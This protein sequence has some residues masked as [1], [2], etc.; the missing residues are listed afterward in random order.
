MILNVSG[1][2]D[3]VAFYSDWF[4]NRYNEGFVDVRNPFN[5]KMI[6]RIYFEDVDAILFCTKNPTPMLDKIQ[7]I[8]K[9]ILFH[10]TLTPYKRD[11]ELNVPDKKDVINSIK[12]LSKIIGID[13]L[14][15]RYDPIFISD[16]YTVDYHIKA[17]DKLCTILNGYV[18]YFIVSFI[19]DYKNVRK[20][21]KVLNYKG[22]TED[23][24]K[25][26]GTNFSKSA[27]NNGMSVQTCFEDRNLVEYGFKK[28]ENK[29]IFKNKIYNKQFEIVVI[30][31]DKQKT[32]KL[33]DLANDEEYIMVDIQDC[34]GKFVGEIRQEYE[35]TIQDI[36]NKCTIDEI[37]KNQQSKEVIKYIKEKYDDDLEFLWKKYDNNAIW[38]NKQNNKWYGVLLV[39]SSKKLGLDYD[40]EIEILDLR[41][42]KDEIDKI[43]DN[44]KIYPG[45]H[46]NKKSWITINLDNT[47]NINKIYK[48]IDNSYNLIV[49]N[50]CGLTGDKLSQKVYDYLITIPKGKVV[51]YKQIGEFLGNKGLARAIGNILHKNPDGDKYP[52]YKVLNSKGE[53]AEAF[54]FG[55]KDIQRKRLEKDGIKVVNN[56]VDLKIYQW[57]QN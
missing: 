10:V 28:Q 30:I 39:I 42:Q 3:I 29:Y 2:T 23:D 34:A 18:K 12:K 47:V 40:K 4:M 54:V 20:N 43:I 1:R 15:I 25:M 16:K 11:I 36:I 27:K 21:E 19:D 45:Y 56:K 46:M 24:Y 9:P 52:C 55:G 57:K 31:S 14:Y 22:F 17:F 35:K 41:Y 13:N 53:L 44:K 38:R 33:I 7:K 32:S 26:I 50:K 49:G 51:T 5:P 37:Y 6:S 8:A 48:L